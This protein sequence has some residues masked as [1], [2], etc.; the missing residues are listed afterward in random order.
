MSEPGGTTARKST[1]V[2]GMIT[3]V[4]ASHGLLHSDLFNAHTTLQ[5]QHLGGLAHRHGVWECRNSCQA[6]ADTNVRSRP[7]ADIGAP[8]M[9]V[10]VSDTLWTLQ[11]LVEQTS[12]QSPGCPTRC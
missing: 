4:I 6:E 5:V 10:S 3:V 8:A 1:I 2:I 9:A 12:P 7:K 11:E